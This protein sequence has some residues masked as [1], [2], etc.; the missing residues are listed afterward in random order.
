MTKEKITK[1]T[2]KQ[3]VICPPHMQ[4]WVTVYQNQKHIIVNKQSKYESNFMQIG[5]D[6]WM[7]A[8]RNLK[9]CS[10]KLYLYMASNMNKFE[11]ALSPKAV[12]NDIGMSESAYR[13]AVEEL[14]ENGYLVAANVDNKKIHGVDFKTYDFYTTPQACKD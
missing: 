8:A 13:R 9:D 4:G 2:A 5:N 12:K 14:E 10:L 7:A 11:F 3:A 6:E 1:E